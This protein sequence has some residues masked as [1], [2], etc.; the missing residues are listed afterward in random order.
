MH[1]RTGVLSGHH[2]S[3]TLSLADRLFVR[4]FQ[5]ASDTLRIR[6]SSP[7]M[8]KTSQR[9]HAK[10]HRMTCPFSSQWLDLPVRSTSRHPGGMDPRPP[11]QL[12]KHVFSRQRFLVGQSMHCHPIPPNSLPGRVVGQLGAKNLQLWEELLQV[13]QALQTSPGEVKPWGLLQEA[14]PRPGS[15]Q[16][17]W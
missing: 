7:Q 5:V 12:F 9:D 17:T 1:S 4:V 15:V 8:P 10:H 6:F 2:E 3:R 16:L 13:F 14:A 11:S